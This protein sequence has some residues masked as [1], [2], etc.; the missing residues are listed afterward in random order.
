MGSIAGGDKVIKADTYSSSLL[1]KRMDKTKRRRNIDASTPRA[2]A[3]C[4]TM[5]A[6]I[7]IAFRTQMRRVGHNYLARWTTMYTASLEL[8]ICQ[9]LHL[10]PRQ[11]T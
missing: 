9:L 7:D 10:L 1:V 2:A 11:L 6:N 5:S 8:T 3:I 4:L